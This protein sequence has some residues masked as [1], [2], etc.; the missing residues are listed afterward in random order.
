MPRSLRAMLP[1]CLLAAALRVGVCPRAPAPRERR[2]P[3]PVVPARRHDRGQLRRV[4]AHCAA[5]SSSRCR[6]AGSTTDDAAAAARQPRRSRRSTGRAPKPTPRRRA[7]G[8]SP[9]PA[10]RRSSRASAKPWPTHAQPGRVH[11]GSGQAAGDCRSRAADARR[12]AGAQLRLSRQRRR[13]ARRAA[14]RSRLRAA[15]RGR[16]VALRPEPGGQRRRRRRRCRCCRRRRCARASSR[17]SCWR[18]RSQDA[19]QRIV[20]AARHHRRAGRPG[21]RGRLGRGAARRGRTPTW[22]S[23]TRTDQAYADLSARMLKAADERV[24]RADVKG[25]EALIRDVLEAD[26]RLGRQRPQETAALLAT[27]DLRLDA[28]RRLRL[29]I[30]SG[31]RSARASFAPTSGRPG[32]RSTRSAARA[33]PLEQI[34]QLAGPSS[35]TLRQLQKNAGIAVA[36]V[37][38]DQAGARGGRGARPADER[39]PDGAARR[40]HAH[41][42]G[43]R[44]R[45][46]PRVAGVVGRG[47]RAAAARSRA[48]GAAAAHDSTR[49]SDHASHHQAAARAGPPDPARRHRRASSSAGGPLAARDC[50]VLVPTRG[51]AEALR[52]TLENRALAAPGAV[53]VLP[54]LADARRLLRPAAPA[55]CRD[56]P[57]LLSEFEREVLVRRAARLASESG[58]PAPFRLRAGLIVEILALYDELRRRGRTVDDFERLMTGS[59]EPS[60]DSDRG[61]ERMLRQ[62]RF[63]VAVFREL[64]RRIAR[65][66]PHRRARP[67]RAAAR[68]HAARQPLPRASIVTVGDQAGDAARALAAPTT[69]CWRASPGLERIDVLATEQVLAAGLHQRLHD[70]FPGLEEERVDAAVL[71]AGARRARAA[72]RSAGRPLVRVAR[73][74]GGAGRLRARREAARR[75]RSAPRVVFQRP[76]PYLYLARSVFADAARAVSGARRAA[77]RGRAVCRGAGSRVRGRDVGSDPRAAG[78]PARLAALALRRRRRRRGRPA[79]VAALDALLREIKYLGGWDRLDALAAE[80]ADSRGRRDRPPRGASAQPALQAAA[81]AAARAA[82]GD[83]GADGLRPGRRGSSRFVKRHERLPR[84]RTNRRSGS[85]AGARARSS[86]RCSALADAHAAHDDEP[87]LVTELANTVRRWIEGQTFSPRTGTEGV[88]L[89][90]AQRAAY[91]DVDE[92]R[93]V[94]LVESDWP[95]RSRRSI[96]YPASLLG[97]LGWPN[98]IDRLTRGARAVPRP[99][100]ARAARASRSRPSRSKTTPSSRRRRSS[101]RSTTVRPRGRARRL[102]PA[103]ARRSLQEALREVPGGIRCTARGAGLAAVAGSAAEWLALRAA[104]IAWRPTPA[105][106]GAAGPRA[107]IEY[108]VSHVERYLDCPFK[109]FSSYVLGLEEERDEDA[110]PEPARA[111]TVPPR[112][113]PAVLRRLAGGRRID[114]SRPTRCRRRW[115]SSRPSS[116]RS[117]RRCRRPTG[118]SS[119]PICSAPPPRR[120]WRS[121]RSRSR[122]S[123]AS[124]SSS[125]CSSTRSKGSSSSQGEDGPVRLRIRGKAD[126]IDLLEDGTLRVVDYKLGRAPKPARALQLPVYGVCASQ[127]LEGRHGRSWPLVAR[128]L[129]RVPR[130]ERLRV[131]RR[132]VRRRPPQALEDGQRRMVAAVAGDRAGTFPG[133]SRRAVPLHALRLCR[134]LPEG[135]RRR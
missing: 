80:P 16:A 135:L 18:A 31:G 121:A 89:L 71:G 124:A 122:S 115:R 37:R 99:A 41:D 11:R 93:L 117:S 43:H 47:R 60:A 110:G 72:G 53:A 94:G 15:R 36:R 54:D 77:A 81:A 50:A 90:D 88:T 28:A 64:E 7:P 21:A 46:E 111:R 6:S 5:P 78:R 129:R 17:R 65:H 132:H 29:A 116:R 109:Y 66:R 130:E 55:T 105:F 26:D 35:R 61:A 3:V 62:T 96:F 85:R 95:E 4:R 92:V 126:R 98:E 79:G 114:R 68:R 74:G 25:V 82:G 22:S 13:A 131:A 38:A 59:L 23:S 128:R 51:A 84:T 1:R 40:G 120:A 27:M 97:Q 57:P 14:R 104:R 12:L 20:A 123:R 113:V 86:A 39:V 9:R 8:S 10:A 101:R 103:A 70:T 75:S 24:R 108:A 33:P 127:Q 76:L 30:G 91:A 34:R 102:A 44:Q 73:P 119:A 133:R 83:R 125:G 52:R 69:I 67:A 19:A 42:R 49:H 118:R 87:L 58:A 45:H 100:A 63:L 134:R 32:R 112:G 48:R 107:P 2:H 56:A 106:H